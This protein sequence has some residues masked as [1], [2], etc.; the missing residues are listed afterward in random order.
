MM[1]DTVQHVKENGG[2]PRL[3]KIKGQE[4]KPNHRSHCS[5]EPVPAWSGR[6]RRCSW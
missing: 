3:L 6:L 5:D 1:L 4:K 2:D